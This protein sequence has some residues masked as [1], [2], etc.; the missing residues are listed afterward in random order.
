MSCL[1][2]MVATKQNLLRDQNAIALLVGLLETIFDKDTGVLPADLE[3]AENFS[4]SN[5]VKLVYRLLGS[6]MLDNPENQ[7]Q[8]SRKS[9]LIQ[10]HIASIEEA[11]DT[12]RI[13]FKD[14]RDLLLK[15]IRPL[16][17]FLPPESANNPVRAR[18]PRRT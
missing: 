12:L 1:K 8:L 17:S 9:G 13:L 11:R 15:V 7:S 14:N 4:V 5:I 2:G 10:S 3:K 6:L 18:S 16:L